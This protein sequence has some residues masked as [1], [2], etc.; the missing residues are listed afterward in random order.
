MWG[1]ASLETRGRTRPCRPRYERENGFFFCIQSRFGWAS[2]TV[3]QL[4]KRGQCVMVEVGFF[5][6]EECALLFRGGVLLVVISGG[7]NV[8]YRCVMVMRYYYWH[9]EGGGYYHV[10]GR[11]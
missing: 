8:E 7:S 2:V 9:G 11:G 6:S 4:I 5:H 10:F 3:D 1:L